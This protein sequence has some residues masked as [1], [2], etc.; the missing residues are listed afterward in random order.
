MI[1]RASHL[2]VPSTHRCLRRRLPTGFPFALKMQILKTLKI[3]LNGHTHYYQATK[4]KKSQK[5]AR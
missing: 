2:S 5:V 3:A 1:T 4:L